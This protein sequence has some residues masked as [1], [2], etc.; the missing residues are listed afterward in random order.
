MDL[1]KKTYIKLNF[2][3]KNKNDALNQI[4][5]WA[6]ELNL[7]SSTKKLYD[8]LLERENQSSTGFESQ[9]AIPH[10][11]SETILKTVFLFVTF[12]KPIDWKSID[13]QLTKCAFVILVKKEDKEKEHLEILTNISKALLDNDFITKIKT[14]SNKNDIF[15]LIQD[16]VV[17]KVNKEDTPQAKIEDSLNVLA[18]TACPVGVAHTYLAAEKL[19]EA[20]KEMKINLKVETHGSSGIKNEFTDKEIQEAD[21]IIVAS[22][23]GLDLDRFKNKTIYQT[24]VKNAIYNPTDV[25]NQASTEAKS[26][27]DIKVNKTQKTNFDYPNQGTIKEKKSYVMKHLLAGISYMVPFVILGG[28][29]IALSVGLGKIIF[30][31]GASA[32]Q[33]DFLYYLEQIGAIAFS[34]M[35][36]ILGAYIANSIAGRA[37][38]APA[39]IVSVLGNTPNA[40][41]NIGGITVVTAMGFIGSILFGLLIGYTVKWVNNWKIPKSISAI[42]PIF[43]IPLGVGL[44]YSLLTIFVI[45]APIGFVMDKFIGALQQ[46]FSSQTDGLSVG[47]GI[48]FGILIGAMTGFDM[49]GPI[50]KVAFLTCSA[51]ITAKIYE[52][53]GLMAAAIPIAPLGMG[54]ASVIFTKKF[55]EQEKT[56]GIS[57]LLMGFIG[58]SEGAIPFAVSDPKRAIICNVFGSAVAGAIAGAFGVTNVAAHGGPIVAILGAVGSGR[59]W[60][61]AGGIGFFFLAIIIGTLVTGLLYGFIKKPSEG[62]ENNIGNNKNVKSKKTFKQFFNLKSHKFV[63]NKIVFQLNNL[64]GVK[65]V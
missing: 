63:L 18:L 4:S 6:K 22:D 45:G 58:I 55:N 34:L 32:P 62:I 49:G 43:I 37:A 23:I 52:P 36:G 64:L 46:A 48:G 2:E 17:N 21:V 53:M 31:D 38:I 24:S 39:F 15:S 19:N 51:L 14:T 44:F 41:F 33:G 5:K 13:N 60:G 59:S 9:I 20:G 12:K 7:V 3:V 54:L 40:L 10:S 65:Y 25:I 42:M 61:I 50:N 57:A 35:I 56:L 1:F 26:Q 47:L 30:G 27:P 16:N 29:C 11:Q 8:S 28:I